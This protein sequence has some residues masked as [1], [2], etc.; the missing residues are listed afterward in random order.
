[1]HSHDVGIVTFPTLGDL[2]SAWIERHCRIPDRHER[3][4]P[5][6]EY[7]WQ[8]WCT[9]N[10]G[11]IREGIEHDPEHPLLNQAFVYRRSQVIGPQKLGK[12]PWVA[13]RVCLCAVGPSEFAGWAK[14]GDVYRCDDHGCGC[15]W[16]WEYEPGEPMGRRH[17]SPLIQIVATS[18]DQVAN[19][20]RPLTSMIHLG[21]L[22]ELLLPRGEFIRIVGEA[23]DRD[24]DRI[25]RVTASAKSRLGAPLNEAFF[26]ETGLYTAGNGLVE[27][28]TTMRRGAA[29][30]GGRSTE[31]TNAFDPGQNSTAQR[32][33]E[34]QRPDIFRFWRDPDQALTRKDG[35][36]L[37]FRN[38]RERRRILEFVY[39]GAEHVSIDSVDAEALEL[40]ETNLAEAERFFGNRKARGAGAWLPHGLWE[41]AWHGLAS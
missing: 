18:D 9:A 13:C 25:D 12:G 22:R 29:A 7:D 33:Q 5:F 3:G 39:A 6:R 20:W 21:P 15:G 30:M 2:W 41:A 8:F 37:S 24:F 11:R 19:I 28:C 23:G 26:D 31:T 34:S 14:A 36:L 4:R 16:V 1:M 10:H 40:M 32:T 27:M 38:A 35:K 17:P